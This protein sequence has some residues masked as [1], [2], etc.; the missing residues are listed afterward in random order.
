MS[1]RLLKLVIASL[2]RHS[3]PGPENPALLRRVRH[4]VPD[5]AR[6]LEHLALA[7]RPGAPR[8]RRGEP[9]RDLLEGAEVVE[10][11]KAYPQMEIVFADAPRARAS[12]MWHRPS[13]RSPGSK[14]NMR[15][16]SAR[17]W[18]F[19]YSPM[20]FSCLCTSQITI[21]PI[22][23]AIAPDQRRVIRHSSIAC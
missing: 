3:L 12:L 5:A 14:P 2:L 8:A 13:F 23:M 9:G 21:R 17:I 4:A 11:A 22:R 10:R 6:P 16:M 7:H 19:A 15:F 20:S 18:S 1:H